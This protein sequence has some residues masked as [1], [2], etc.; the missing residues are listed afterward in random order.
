MP[1]NS[2]RETTVP[3]APAVVAARDSTSTDLDRR[4]STG[5]EQALA[6]YRAIFVNSTEAIAIIDPAGHYLEQN[7]AH[8]ALLGWSIAELRNQ[9]PAIHMGEEQFAT[10]ADALARNGVY[11][12][13]LRS[14]TRSGTFVDLELSAFAV[15]DNTGTPVCY[16]DI[17][18]DVT[19]RARAAAEQ[20]R[21]FGQLQTLYRMSRALGHAVGVDAIYEE[22]LASLREAFHTERASILLFDDDRAMR[23]KA[24]RGLSEAYRAA[25]EGHSPWRPDAVDP[26][27]IVVPDV[28]QD[29]TLASFRRL[30]DAEGIRAL[31]FIPLVYDETLLGKFMLY[32][33]APRPL[34]EEETHLAVAIA[35]HIAFAIARGR[36][37]A[38]RARLFQQAQEA[39]LAKSQFLAT[40]SH[41]LRTPLNAIAGYTELLELGLHGQLTDLQREDL[42]RIRVN[43]QHL[44]SLINDVLSFAKIETGHM[45]MEIAGVP[46]DE[47]LAT[48]RALV[49]P[50]LRARRLAFHYRSG[51]PSVTVRADREKLQQIVLNL[52]SNAIKFT[53]VGGDITLEWEAGDPD[54]QIRVIDSGAG[55]P[56]EKLELIFEPFVQLQHGFTRG[57][58]G[59]GLGLAICRELARAMGGDV[60]VKSEV[61]AG[62]TFTVTVPKH[63]E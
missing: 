56:E 53:P 28:Y 34:E 40:M 52:L 61:G 19:D 21:R 18:R 41:E 27:P 16:V 2:S 32:F 30:F 36:A 20:Q 13:E 26:Q 42:T 49:E 44:L 15:T 39:N 55:I 63:R 29:E 9:T 37:E 47:S 11:R 54:V 4:S 6:L 10:V 59:S 35:S 33:D 45:E 12:G 8:R 62:A 50:Q 31:A 7:D 14:R 5:T 1:Q 23:F 43:Q 57:T 17:K 46:L 25:V 60:T 3:R 22:A 58:E 38:E 48:L 51:D 24:W